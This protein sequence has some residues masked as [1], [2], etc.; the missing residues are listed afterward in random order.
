VNGTGVPVYSHQTGFVGAGPAHPAT[1]EYHL[2]LSSPPADIT[3]LVVA[4]GLLS[5]G[6]P[7]EIT[8]VFNGV[9]EIIVFTFN[10][11]GV[12]TDKSFSVV[13]YDLTP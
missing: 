10:S 11:A 2:Q 3:F 8:W 4:P 12:A 1:G 5:I 6:V 9:D 7:G 13:V